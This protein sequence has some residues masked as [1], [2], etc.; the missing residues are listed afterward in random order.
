M[1]TLDDLVSEELEGDPDL[2]YHFHCDLA[3]KK[4]AVGLVLSA[5]TG[6]TEVSRS[7]EEDRKKERAPLVDHELL[8]QIKAPPGGEI[9]F[10]DVRSILYWLK[11]DRG[12]RIKRSSF[13]GWQSLDSIQLMTRRGFLVEVLSVDRDQGPHTTQKDA[14]YERRLFFPPAHGQ[15][16]DTTLEELERM[17]NAGDPLRRLS[18]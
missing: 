12:F 11:D 18:N 15:T 9:V 4:D 2:W 10:E 16:P 6:I 5:C 1:L 7:R 13:D 17:A 3:Q 8:I 14:L